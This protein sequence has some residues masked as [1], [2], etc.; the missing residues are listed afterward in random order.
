M[1]E[2][3]GGKMGKVVEYTSYPEAYQDL[4]LRRT[5][6]VVN[7]IINVKALVAEKPKVFEIGLPVSGKSYPG[8]GGG[9]GEYELVAL[10]NEFM[11]AERP[12]AHPELQEKWFG[13]SWPDL[14]GLHAGVS[15]GTPELGSVPSAAPISL[16][17]LQG[18]VTTSTA[19]RSSASC[20]ACRW[21]WASR[22]SDGRACR[23][24][25][26]PWPPMSACCAPRRSSR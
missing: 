20:S 23:S 11:A 17:L 12:T 15:D 8:L 18:A 22:S 24:W 19:C 10:L 7:T 25:G 21:G 13:Q 14:P 5:D 16:A 3:T 26:R 1:I 2:K 4:S 6:F 9:E